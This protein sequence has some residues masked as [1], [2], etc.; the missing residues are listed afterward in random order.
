MR[1]HPDDAATRGIADGDVVLVHNDRGAYYAGAVVSDAVR[2]VV[3]QLSTGAWWTPAEPDEPG[4][5]CVAGNPNVL[6]ADRGTSRL[7]QGSIGQLTLVEVSRVDGP[8]PTRDPYAP[9][10]AGDGGFPG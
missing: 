1:I 4:S 5:P 6:T 8:V 2:P 10:L 7:A 9:P 3:V